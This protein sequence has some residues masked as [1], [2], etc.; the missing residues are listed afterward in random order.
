MDTKTADP[1]DHPWRMGYTIDETTTPW[2]GKWHK[3]YIPLKN[4]KDQGAWDN[5]WFNSIG[6]YDWKAT[7][8]FLIVSEQGDLK[9]RALWFDNICLTNMDTL[10]IH[11]FTITSVSIIQQND[12]RISM[13]IYPNPANNYVT[14]EYEIKYTEDV[15]I[16]IFNM[17]GQKVKSLL[18]SRQ[19]P[20]IYTIT[21][22]P[23]DLKGVNNVS[24]I[25]LCRIS[26]SG[27]IFTRKISFI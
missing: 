23:H 27:K 2:D 26:L 15:C 16:D 8:N 25:Y 19:S 21:W 9:G 13:N 17:N 20:G 10:Q 7:D 14:I 22:D 24:G 12:N 18:R 4:F 11:N 3:I 6:A 5:G 1:K